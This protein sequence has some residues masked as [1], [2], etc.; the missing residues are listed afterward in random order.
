MN[1]LAPNLRAW[2][3][4]FATATEEAS[5]ALAVW[6]HGD[7]VLSVDEISETSL[8]EVALS[9][10]L[11]EE[12]VTLVR[13]GIDG[14]YGGQLLLSFDDDNARSLIQSLLRRPASNGGHW[15]PLELSALAETG[16][17]LASIYM[18]H[19]T[20]L[21]GTRLWPT[22]PDVMR[23]YAMSVVQQAVLSQAQCEDRVMLCKTRFECMGQDVEW[24]LVLIPSPELM[25][26]IERS[27][28]G[29]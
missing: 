11:S 26:V 10:R 29:A 6:T 8:S 24:S 3:A 12:L 18:N 19:L 27:L 9:L 1:T 16:N 20:E 5:T 21:T 22:P 14:D 17:I 13:F 25:Q 4:F 7:V 2:K 15:S 23:D 28:A